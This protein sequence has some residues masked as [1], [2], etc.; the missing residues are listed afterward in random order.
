[1]VRITALILAFTAL[2]AI[3]PCCAD[4]HD[5]LQGINKEI[6]EKKI[7]LKKVKKVENKVSGDLEKI[8]K[9]LHEKEANLNSLGR[10]LKGV[11]TTLERTQRE[12]EVVK[13]EAER[14]KQQIKQRLAALYKAGDPGPV[15]MFFS[16]ESFP[17]MAENLR[18]MNSVLQNDRKLFAEYNAKIE[19]L[20]A[21]KGTLEKDAERKEKIKADIEVKKQ[22]IE[23]EKKKKAA[24]LLKIR[25]DRKSYLASLKELEANARRLQAMVER[26]EAKSR[27]SYSKKI[28]KKSGTGA[29]HSLPAFPDKG[30]GAQRGRLA[31]PVK[32]EI[33]GTFGR[34]KHPEFNSYTVSN[35]IS[36]AAPAGADIHSVYEGQ[37]IF[38]DY[39]KG[40]GNMVIVDH[41]GGFFSLYGHAAKIIKKVGSAV[42]RND[43][44]ASV[45]DVDSAKGPMLYFEIRYQGKPVDP[46][47]WFR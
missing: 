6:R 15:R 45:G 46:A 26:L 3:E 8:E 12:I 23:G 18:Y 42:A 43:V 30:F 33:I 38:A 37:V 35:G 24:Y 16:S 2:L 28:E 14:K 25:E 22:E 20:G 31:I 36:I 32:G 29:D 44:V 11:E 21:L 34:H 10:D 9:S 27:K 40:Y 5:D 1:M 4:V 7:L 13:G 41:G 47:P 19:R 39:F 17:Q